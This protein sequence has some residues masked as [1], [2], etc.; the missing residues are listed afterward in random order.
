MMTIQELAELLH[1]E[2]IGDPQTEIRGIE[3]IEYAEAGQISFI[4]NQK[5]LRYETQTL[6]SALI[7]SAAHTPQRT[8]IT[9]IRTSDPYAGFV[10]LLRVFYPSQAAYPAGIHPSA[11]VEGSTIDPEAYIGPTAVVGEGSTVGGKSQVHAG[12]IIGRNVS[13]GK[14]STIYPNVVI[15]DG[16]VIGDNVVIHSGTIIGSDGFG[17]LQRQTHWEKIPQLGIVTI[18]NDVEI[19]ANCTID[20]ATMGETRIC[21]GTKVDNLV[22]IAHNVIVGEHTVIAAQSG[23]SGSTRLGKFNMLG[24]QVGLVGHI[25]T[26]DNVIVEAQSGVSKNISKSGRYFGHPAK[27]HGLALRQEAAIRQLPDALKEI[28]ELKN[29]LRELEEKL[30]LK[31]TD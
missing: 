5:Y 24:G 21:V 4:A 20:R 9:Y 14:N 19:G 26:T 27:E 7:V 12:V 2:I 6:A 17:Y 30:V 8:D 28:Q 15:Y 11:V 16:C 25:T 18:E 13:I 3:K 22:H 23:I 31:Q 29:K 1:G 10:Q